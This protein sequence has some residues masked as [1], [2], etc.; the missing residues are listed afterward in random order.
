MG[1]NQPPSVGWLLSLIE[2]VRIVDVD[3]SAVYLRDGV[4]SEAIDQ[5]DGVIAGTA[6]EGGNELAI[7]ALEPSYKGGSMG[8][9]H[10]KRLERLVA[11][12]TDR[13]LPIIRLYDSGGVRAQEGG[14]SL[15]EASALLGQLMKA[16]DAV[17]VVNAVMGTTTGAATYAAYMG[18]V[19]IMTRGLS[20]MFVWGPGVA[21]AETGAEVGMED[22]GGAEVQM[23]TGRCLP[24]CGRRLKASFHSPGVFCVSSTKV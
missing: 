20:R 2:D 21:K 23:A 5:D 7:F 14:N 9:K 22:L 17:P 10:A 1:A 8:L 12:A 4:S 13:K 3:G 11:I 16:K 15:E 6:R 18:D 24:N 19:L